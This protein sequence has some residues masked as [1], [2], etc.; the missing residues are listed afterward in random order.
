MLEH[1]AI[2]VRIDSLGI[3]NL[4]SQNETILSTIRK[5]LPSAMKLSIIMMSYNQGLYMDEAISSVFNQHIPTHW[6]WELIIGDDCSTDNSKEIILRWQRKYPDIIIPVLRKANIGLHNNYVDLVRRARGEYVALLEADDYWIS[7][8]K[9]E[10]QINFLDANESVSWCF[11]NGKWVNEHGKETKV[12]KHKLPEIFN[13]TFFLENFF[14][15]LNN[16][17]IFR[18]ST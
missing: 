17:I 16:S 7:Q 3:C 2:G 12:V 9:T 6:K 8:K 15:P 13:L 5:A 14:I 1:R 18:K 10:T 11:T 4:T